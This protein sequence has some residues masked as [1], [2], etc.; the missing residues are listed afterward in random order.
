MF[1]AVWAA[2]HL[3]KIHRRVRRHGWTAIYVGDYETAPTWVYTLGFDETLNQPEII[4]FDLP[5][6]DANRLLWQVFD[7]LRAGL[8]VLDDGKAWPDGEAHP[9]VW[10][11]VH[12]SQIDTAEGWLALAVRR[13]AQRTGFN[14]G[15]E[16]FQLVLSDEQGRLPWQD[17]YDE[18]LRP[19]Q[20]ELY[21]SLDVGGS[22][23]AASERL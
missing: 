17:G 10:R 7:E 12:P 6:T 5:Q 20:P 23:L 22:Q 9:A 2:W 15:L 3:F 19:L 4:V 13:R 14:F 16:A 1:E 8:L 21:L 11:K 18:R